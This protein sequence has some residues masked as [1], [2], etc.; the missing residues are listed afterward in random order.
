[1]FFHLPVSEALYYLGPF[2]RNSDQGM[3]DDSVFVL[4]SE[5]GDLLG[6]KHFRVEQETSCIESPCPDFSIVYRGKTAADGSISLSKILFT[7]ELFSYVDGKEL[8]HSR[9]KQY[10]FHVEGNYNT[11][12]SFDEI[13][14]YYQGNTSTQ[15]EL[16]AKPDGYCTAPKQRSSFIQNYCDGH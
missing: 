10:L 3:T 8:I 4:S 7:D 13:K 5:Q 6:C 14:N 15:L 9:L 11:Q 1:M 12:I 2:C 16:T